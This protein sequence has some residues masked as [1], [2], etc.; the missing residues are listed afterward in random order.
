MQCLCNSKSGLFIQ[1]NFSLFNFCQMQMWC[2]ENVKWKFTREIEKLFNFSCLGMSEINKLI[3]VHCNNVKFSESFMKRNTFASCILISYVWFYV[4]Y[5][6][7][8]KFIHPV[9]ATDVKTLKLYQALKLLLLR[10]IK[11]TTQTRLAAN[12]CLAVCFIPT[13]LIRSSKN[14]VW[15]RDFI[16]GDVNAS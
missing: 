2:L 6:I 4:N 10:K 15:S 16:G 13:F 5:F 14:C 7:S 8:G 12:S 1:L 3:E 11:S 9:L